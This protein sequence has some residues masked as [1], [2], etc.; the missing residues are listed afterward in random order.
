MSSPS[1]P[2]PRPASSEEPV[3]FGYLPE[4]PSKPDQRPRRR[5]RRRSQEAR[6]AGQDGPQPTPAGTPASSPAEE[7]DRIVEWHG[8]RLLP[9]QIQAVDAVRKGHNVLVAAPTGA[10]KTLVAEY[11]VEDAVRRGK[12]VVYTS[13]IKALSSQKYRD[14]KEEP[15]VEVG[16]MT[17]DVTLNARAQVLVMTTEILRNAIFENPELI[18]D[19]EFVVFDEVHFLDDRERGM[20]WEECFIFLPPHVRLICLS[21][22]IQN[23]EELGSWIGQVRPQENVVILE[24]R[25]PVPLSHWV[26]TEAASTF[27]PGR[28]GHHRKKAGEAV[29][30]E[31]RKERGSRRGRGGRRRGRER[32]GPPERP[33]AKGLIDELVDDGRLPALVF[34]FSRK[35]VE[36]LA[37]RNQRRA[38]LD[39]EEEARMV[40]LQDELLEVFQLPRKF[41]RGE[42]MQMALRGVAY[43]HAGL[44]PV[45]K[46]LVERMFT[47][48]LI[49]LLFTTE[50]FALG[51]NMPARSVVFSQ[52]RKY[53]GISM[54]WLRTRDYMQMA[55]RAG[56]QGI[57]DK[58]FVYSVLSDRELTEAPLERLFAGK[59]EPVTS[60]F[61]LSYSTILHLVEAAGRERLY[62]AWERSFAQYQ[63]RGSSR[64]AREHQRV[65]Q[66][67]EVDRRLELLTELGYLDGE[68]VTPRGKIARLLSG[69]EIQV[70]ELLFSGALENLPPKAVVMIFVALIHEERGRFRRHVPAKVFGGLRRVVTGTVERAAGLERRAGIEPGMK[71]PDWGL[72]EAVLAWYGGAPVDELED[73]M[74]A[75]LGDFCRVLRMAIQL[76]RNTRRSIDRDWDLATVLDEA[77]LAVNRDEIDARRQL[78]LG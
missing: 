67:R 69:H 16:I 64:K 63:V 49:K 58:G 78:E 2:A 36:R 73:H 18:E 41:L 42:L 77:V 43:H 4:E 48:G 74:D 39:D 15:E 72:S 57:D 7:G 53:D 50:T 61:R 21:A 55:G 17:G 62:E 5:R 11:A 29:E 65:A 31:R 23:V 66:R 13:P 52:L 25:R 76:M 9:F 33:D 54:D 45:H 10:G 28:L 51:I 19:V 20:V 24:D 70:T 56:R 60:R 3:P 75:T 59:P 14:F 68:R 27:P 32:G 71:L 44:L 8:F 22:T 46:E 26:H 47:A 37:H 30:R 40:A 1:D 38:L 34:S 12:R 35:D 6:S